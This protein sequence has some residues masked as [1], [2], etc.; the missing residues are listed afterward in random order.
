MSTT[1][2]KTY[3]AELTKEKL[4][5]EL[6]REPTAGEVAEDIER[7]DRYLS[8]LSVS[9]LSEIRDSPRVALRRVRQMEEAIADAQSASFS[10]RGGVCPKRGMDK[11]HRMILIL[12][13]FLLYS[14]MYIQ[15]A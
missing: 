5:L 10:E 9:E 2:L 4:R 14:H 11:Y 13:D 1:E 12:H 8:P 3:L 6:K 7:L 15:P